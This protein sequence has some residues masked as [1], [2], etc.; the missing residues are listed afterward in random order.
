MINKMIVSFDVEKLYD[1][2][3]A[4]GALSYGAGEMID[5]K[6]YQKRDKNKY[7]GFSSG[8][9]FGAGVMTTAVGAGFLLEAL[10]RSLKL[11]K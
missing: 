11:G 2:L 9:L 6:E 8:A 7:D 1:A 4:V 3:W 10:A 5:A